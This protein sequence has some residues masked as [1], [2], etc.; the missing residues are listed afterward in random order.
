MASSI[1]TTLKLKLTRAAIVIVDSTMAD[2]KFWRSVRQINVEESMVL[3]GGSIRDTNALD[4]L[5]NIDAP[6]TV[7][8]PRE[9]ISLLENGTLDPRDGSS[10]LRGYFR[11]TSMTDPGSQMVVLTTRPRELAK[12][13]TLAEVRSDRRTG[14]ITLEMD[15]GGHF[16]EIVKAVKALAVELVHP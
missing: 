16:S 12:M 3:R 10:A 9:D 8:S 1:T 13:L 6:K 4:L 11:V 7:H 14:T 5:H 2:R 15:E